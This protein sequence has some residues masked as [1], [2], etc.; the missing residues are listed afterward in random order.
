M[1]ASV[2]ARGRALSSVNLVKFH[3]ADGVAGIATASTDPRPI[4]IGKGRPALDCTCTVQSTW[5]RIPALAT[6]E[7]RARTKNHLSAEIQQEL[8]TLLRAFQQQTR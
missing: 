3:C 2:L 7:L 8:R 5:T 6:Q 4:A 1:A